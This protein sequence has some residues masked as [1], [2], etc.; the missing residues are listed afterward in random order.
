MVDMQIAIRLHRDVDAGMPGQEIEH[1]VEEADAG[2]DMGHARSVE[3]D[4][5]LDVGL[6]GLALDR[7]AAHGS[8]LAHCRKRR[9]F[10]RRM[11]PSL[12]RYGPIGPQL[13]PMV[14]ELARL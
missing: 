9:S 14:S 13:L 6:L 10:N 1:M 11:T 7:R 8:C 4:R 2:C 12:L 5:N 3:V